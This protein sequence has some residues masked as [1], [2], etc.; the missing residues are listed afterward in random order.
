MEAEIESDACDTCGRGPLVLI[1]ILGKL[2]HVRCRVCGIQSSVPAAV[3]EDT[4]E[5]AGYE[6]TDKAETA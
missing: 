5:G 3:F 6:P 2:A 1:G 4:Q